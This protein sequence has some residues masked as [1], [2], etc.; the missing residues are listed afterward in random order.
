M[1]GSSLS[2]SRLL[3]KFKSLAVFC[4]CTARFVS[5]LFGNHIVG[6]LMSQRCLTTHEM[7]DQEYPWNTYIAIRTYEPS[8]EK[9]NNEVF[10][11]VWS[12]QSQRMAK[13]LK[14][15]I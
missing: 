5:G 11:Q 1:T 10:E 6:F 4:A 3:S 7:N 8:H 9:T 15:W 14:F 2:T 12:A 13:S